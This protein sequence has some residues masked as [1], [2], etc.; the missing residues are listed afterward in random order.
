MLLHVSCKLLACVIFELKFV[1]WC[2]GVGV[3]CSF[4]HH[5]RCAWRVANQFDGITRVPQAILG[6]SRGNYRHVGKFVLVFTNGDIVIDPSVIEKN[7]LHGFRVKFN[8][9]QMVSYVVDATR[10]HVLVQPFGAV[11]TA[12]C[13]FAGTYLDFWLGIIVQN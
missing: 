10:L 13:S 2:G 6:G 5:V 9:H 1:V 7:F 3:I 11:L 8:R 12:L 4:D